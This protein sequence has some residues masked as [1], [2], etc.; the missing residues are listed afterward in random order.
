MLAGNLN[1]P[2]YLTLS[3]SLPIYYRLTRDSSDCSLL[4]EKGMKSIV[5]CKFRYDPYH[6]GLV[7]RRGQELAVI[8]HDHR[9]PFMSHP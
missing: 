8:V 7:A 4:T 6:E 3:L 9:Y 2:T 5:T 1:I